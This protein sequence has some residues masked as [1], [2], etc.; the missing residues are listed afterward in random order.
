M[1]P[2]IVLCDIPFRPDPAALIRRLRI[3]DQP[4]YIRR[5]RRLVADGQA[6]ARPKAMYRP[7][8]IESRDPDTVVIDGIRMTSRILRVNLVQAHRVFPYVATCGREMAAWAEG[9]SDLLDRFWADA[10]TEAALREA[11]RILEADIGSR[12]NP[13][14]TGSMNPGSLRD[15]P[16]EEQRKLFQAL[17][18]PMTTIGVELTDSFLMI[19]I[20]SVSGLRF[21]TEIRYEN[22]QLCPRD[23]CPERR[24]PYDRE[25]HARRYGE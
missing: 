7:A 1:E 2:A 24:A 17:G 14:P 9:F 22:C 12:F 19:P 18:D 4:G 5:F 20:K 25:L 10:I 3:P 21:P 11:L 6:V 16:L 8:Y 23:R 13:G 15:W